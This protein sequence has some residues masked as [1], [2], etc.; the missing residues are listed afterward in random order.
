MTDTPITVNGIGGGQT[1]LTGI[2][3]KGSIQRQLITPP[4]RASSC[5]WPECQRGEI[6]Q[7]ANCGP[8]VGVLPIGECERSDLLGE[9]EEKTSVR[10]RSQRRS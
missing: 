2:S 7:L 8:G 3:E 9:V 5:L 1:A 6:G 10:D 4:A